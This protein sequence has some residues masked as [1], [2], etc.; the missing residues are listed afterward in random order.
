MRASQQCENLIPDQTA[1]SSPRS[2]LPPS[3]LPGFLTLLPSILNFTLEESWNSRLAGLGGYRFETE[4]THLGVTRPLASM[5][6][7]VSMLIFTLNWH[8]TCWFIY[9]LTE[10][11]MMAQSCWICGSGFLLLRRYISHDLWTRNNWRVSYFSF[12]RGYVTLQNKL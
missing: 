7:I 2:G 9:I 5:Y 10:I 1:L 4:Y 6:C 12:K 8:L 11:F 3:P